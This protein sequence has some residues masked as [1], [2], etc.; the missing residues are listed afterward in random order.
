MKII[1]WEQDFFVHQR[2]ASAVKRVEFVNDWMSYIFLRGCWRKRRRR[3][4][5]RRRRSSSSSSS[6]FYLTVPYY[7]LAPGFS[8]LTWLLPCHTLRIFPVLNFAMTYFITNL[9]F[10]LTS[11][12]FTFM[13]RTSTTL[14]FAGHG[15]KS[16]NL[17]LIYY[18][19]EGCPFILGI[20]APKVSL[21]VVMGLELGKIYAMPL[22]GA[23]RSEVCIPPM[24]LCLYTSTQSRLLPTLKWSSV[25]R[26]SI[27]VFW[28]GATHSSI[29]WPVQP[30]DFDSLQTQPSTHN[31]SGLAT[32]PDSVS[33]C[34]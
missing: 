15:Y 16:K 12:T 11:V 27:S 22:F 33:H 14:V 9:S 2:I 32:L 4:R 34:W 18:K 8:F 28:T 19:W 5:R 17:W 1:S 23:W 26:H 7:N 3:R 25:L 31:S 6:S 20:N 10:A 13:F 21:I 29:Y 30:P 24:R